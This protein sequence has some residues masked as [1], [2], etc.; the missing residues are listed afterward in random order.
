[1][2]IIFISLILYCDTVPIICNKTMQS[3]QFENKIDKCTISTK[4]HFADDFKEKCEK[5]C[6]EDF[7]TVNVNSCNHKKYRSP[8]GAHFTINAHG[9]K[10]YECLECCT[11]NKIKTTTTTTTTTRF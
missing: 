6:W 4:P 8:C 3:T 1:M 7:Y 11:L 9:Q 2:H 5:K 10:N